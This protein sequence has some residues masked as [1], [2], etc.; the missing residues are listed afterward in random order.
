MNNWYFSED[1]NEFIICSPYTP[2]PWINYLTNGNYFALTSQT[3][4]GFSFFLDP[5]H[6]VITRREQDLLL[7][8]RPGRFV[9]IQDMEDGRYWN[10][11]GNPSATELDEFTCRH[12]FGYTK[13]ESQ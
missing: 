12:G 9:F 10:V 6:H 8:D 7:N 5:L 11:G 1:N 3:G 2:R 4:G 13:I